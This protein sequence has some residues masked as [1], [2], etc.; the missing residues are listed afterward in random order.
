MR[1]NQV[2]LINP[3]AKKKQDQYDIADFPNPTI[4]YLAAYLLKNN[5]NCGV[6]DAKLS[7]MTEGSILDFPELQNTPLVGLTS[8]THE[9]TAAASLAAKIKDKYPEKK[10]IIG[11]PHATALPEQTLRDFPAFDFLVCGEGEKPLL[12]LIKSLAHKE[13][14]GNIKGLSYRLNGGLIIKTEEDPIEDISDMPSAAYELF[15]GC[16]RYYVLT[17]RGCIY[18]CPFCY[19]KSSK[20]RLRSVKDVI[21]DL[22]NLVYNHRP[23]LITI[24][25]DTFNAVKNRTF[26]ILNQIIE[27]NLNKNTEFKATLHARNLDYPLFCRMKEAGFR[28][29]HLGIESG[30]CKIL[31]EIGKGIDKD[32]IRRV[33]RDAKKAQIGVQGLYILGHP[34]ETWDSALDT[35][36][37]A[38]ELNTEEIAIAV[39]VPYP[40]TKIWEYA[41]NNQHGYKNLSLEWEKYSKFFGPAVELENLNKLQ[42]VFLQTIAY[43]GLYLYNLRFIGFIKFLYSFRCEAFSFA[44]TLIK[45]CFPFAKKRTGR[46]FS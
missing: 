14:W 15:P 28:I 45:N 44:M 3:P 5:V 6:V 32:I 26:E 16:R 42:L 39:M 8:M 40:G 17:A 25:D 31:R 34:G 9:V 21:E 24:A 37:F 11:G 29:I 38:I 23:R 2:I 7:R 43:L 19:N 13:E 30:N 1:E 12:N 35:V 33:V 4:S 10:I 22:K 41:K 46:S 18:H 20:L 27:N 36:K